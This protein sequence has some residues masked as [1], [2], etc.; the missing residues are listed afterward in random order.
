MGRQWIID[1]FV[2]THDCRLMKDEVDIGHSCGQQLVVPNISL[3]HLSTSRDILPRPGREIIEDDHVII[4]NK[5]I[6][7]MAPNKP[8]ST[9]NQ[10]S[11]VTKIWM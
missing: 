6:S 9:G 3:N 7:D 4:G 8:S 10:D 2:H 11:V 5:S 1:G